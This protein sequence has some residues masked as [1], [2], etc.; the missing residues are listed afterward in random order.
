MW[1]LAVGIILVALAIA[2]IAFRRHQPGRGQHV[3]DD[4][5]ARTGMGIAIAGAATIPTLGP[6]MLVMTLVGIVLMVVANY[7]SPHDRRL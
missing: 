5:L 2:W 4:P 3:A 1:I 6:I 7:R